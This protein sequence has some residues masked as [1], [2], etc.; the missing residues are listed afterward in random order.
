MQGFSAR[1]T[2]SPVAEIRESQAHLASQEESIGKLVTTYSTTFLGLN[3]DSGLWPSASYGEG[4]IIG[5]IDSR[6][7]PES[8][9]FSDNGMPPVPRQ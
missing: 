7:W 5:L 6:V 4:V 8:L 3:H 2:P 9:S 1:F